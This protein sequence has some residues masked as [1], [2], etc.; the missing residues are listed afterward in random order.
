VI[1]LREREGRK[2]DSPDNFLVSRSEPKKWIVDQVKDKGTR[3][4]NQGP[5]NC[6]LGRD[7]N[8]RKKSSFH[9]EALK[10]QEVQGGVRGSG[11]K[12]GGGVGFLGLNGGISGGGQK[13]YKRDEKIRPDARRY[14]R[15]RRSA[16]Q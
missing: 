1:V 9:E 6:A 3:V 8:E 13:R 12:E 2:N 7:P 16:G 4:T 11:K 15:P 10:K 14:G 5:P